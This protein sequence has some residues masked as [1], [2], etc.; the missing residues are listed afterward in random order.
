MTGLLSVMSPLDLAAFILEEISVR[1]SLVG[2]LP[3]QPGQPGRPTFSASKRVQDL[4]F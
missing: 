1:T 3:G 2:S 4:K